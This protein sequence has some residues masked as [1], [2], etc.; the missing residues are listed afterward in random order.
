MIAF[1]VLA[2][3]HK[4]GASAAAIKKVVAKRKLSMAKFEAEARQRNVLLANVA[5]WKLRASKRRGLDNRYRAVRGPSNLTRS[6]AGPMG[7]RP[8][9]KMHTWLR[10]LQFLLPVLLYPVLAS[11][12]VE[13][14]VPVTREFMECVRES[15]NKKVNP[16]LL[17][18]MKTRIRRAA[19][20]FMR[21]LPASER[22]LLV[23]LVT[24]GPEMIGKLGPTNG[25]HMFPFESFYGY[26]KRFVQSKSD[27]EA[28][29]FMCY[30]LVVFGR[31]LRARY[32]DALHTSVVPLMGVGAPGTV[33]SSSD[34]DDVQ[35]EVTAPARDSVRKRKKL[36]QRERDYIFLLLGKTVRRWCRV[37]SGTISVRRQDRGSADIED[38][39]RKGRRTTRHSGVEIS[40]H[41]FP[42]RF[43]GRRFGVIRYMAYVTTDDDEQHNLVARVQVFKS[44]EERGPQGQVIIDPSKVMGRPFFI[45]VEDLGA[46]VAFVP[47]PARGDGE[48]RNPTS[49][50]QY[51]NRKQYVVQCHPNCEL[52]PNPFEPA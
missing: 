49:A 11:L 52:G 37:L 22:G 20:A 40:G 42:A 24:H 51:W 23:H 30:R 33:D 8:K 44:L 7:G 50:D 29:I 34:D 12:S 17:S 47:V 18:P 9:M 19:R 28:N 32:P 10:V 13:N 43:A 48:A 14:V 38:V 45:R 4:E 1:C 31:I 5:Q 41:H 35:G 16:Q 46:A 26:L 2:G 25:Y 3:P 39:S 15:V 27:P 6:G 36:S 21:I